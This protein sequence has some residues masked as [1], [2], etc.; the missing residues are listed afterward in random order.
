MANQLTLRKKIVFSAMTT[1]AFFLFLELILALCGVRPESET[2]DR[3]VGFSRHLPL[4]QLTMDA[5]GVETFATSES[6]L[7]WFNYQSF[8]KKK[9][10]TTKRIFCMGGSTTYGHPY[11]DETSFAGWLRVYLPVVDPDTNWEVINA[12]GIS[13]ASYRVAALM[14]ELANYEPDLFIVYSV[15]NE[16]LERRTYASMFEQS[17]WMMQ[18]TGLLVKTR[19]WTMTDRLVSLALQRKPAANDRQSTDKRKRGTLAR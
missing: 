7:H 17:N 1:I 10:A 16:F 11:W 4:F 3:F 8:P 13:Y 18:V 19:T 5:Q 14:E 2:T 15:H 12:G 9:S 6:K